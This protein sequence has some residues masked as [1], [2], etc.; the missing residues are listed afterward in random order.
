MVGSGCRGVMGDGTPGRMGCTTPANG[1]IFGTVGTNGVEW[2]VP[3]GQCLLSMVK[4]AKAE[5]EHAKAEAEH[6]KPL[7]AQEV[8]AGQPVAFAPAASASAA[9][10][11]LSASVSRRWRSLAP[12]ASGGQQGN[13]N[14]SLTV[15]ASGA[16][17]AAAAGAPSDVAATPGALMRVYGDGGDRE[18]LSDFR[19]LAD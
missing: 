12:A 2:L 7:D 14:N 11:A 13:D 16:P 8:S 3:R 18:D 6:A 15:A 4:Q 5:A 1:S 17:S 9:S 10:G 19:Q